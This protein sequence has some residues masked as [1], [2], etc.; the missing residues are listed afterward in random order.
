MISP[1]SG[2][3][4]LNFSLNVSNRVRHKEGSAFN[5]A[6]LDALRRIARNL[7]DTRGLLTKTQGDATVRTFR[8]VTGT[9]GGGGGG[10]PVIAQTESAA[11]LG[12]SMVTTPTTLTSTEELN[13]TP[14]SFTPRINNFSGQT[15]TVAMVGGVYDGAQ[16]DTSLTFKIQDNG[17]VGTDQIRVQVKDGNTVLETVTFEAADPP[18]TVKT[19]SNGL[20]LSLSAGT[21]KKNSSFRLDVFST[22]GTDVDPDKPL[23]GTGNNDPELQP[24]QSVI[25][26]QF[27]INGY[28]VDIVDGDTLNDVLG[29]INA[30]GAGVTA[31]YDAGT[32][33]VQVTQNTGGSAPPIILG[34]DNTGFFD[35]TKLSGATQVPGADT[36]LETAID[37]VAALS[38]I[39]GGNFKVN[40][41]NFTINTAT[42]SLQDVI[43]QINAS[44]A[45]VTAAYDQGQDKV[46]ITSNSAGVDL[47]LVD[48][49]S[50]FFAGVGIA[51]GTIS[52]GGGGGEPVEK[53]TE[54]VQQFEGAS[55]LPGLL[56]DFGKS[57]NELFQTAF[58]EDALGAELP[59]GLIQDAI[60]AV[61]ERVFD[62]E[63]GARLR[64][65]LGIEF[66]FDDP[67]NDVVRIDSERLGQATSEELGLLADF[68][69]G[70][71]G[72]NNGL[73]P[74]LDEAFEK[75][76][77]SLIDKLDPVSSHGLL[78]DLR[79]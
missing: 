55:N 65:G 37:Q 21:A 76:G 5:G 46:T 17:V 38:G 71:N 4:P 58:G 25:A 68:L 59:T 70:D 48:G 41:I 26:G 28:S 13:T 27:N 72:N 69:V 3:G 23:N 44:G 73:L 10:P 20:T 32:D 61:F 34:S 60:T 1:I 36:D 54:L 56:D 64:T 35:A 11:A 31:V 39:S 7:V 43:D 50:N 19:L 18:D 2:F 75:F 51:Q 57:L 62:E 53:T 24:G 47:V 67:D 52:G 30:S 78:V 45:N 12:L 66:Y 74:T 79:A 9:V 40:G 6:Q 49:T 33:T 22:V 29:K 63:G 14:T 8:R 16:G 77:E 15:T 42:D